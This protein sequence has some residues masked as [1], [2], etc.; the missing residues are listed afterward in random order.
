MA[1]PNLSHEPPEFNHQL[2]SSVCPYKH[3]CKEQPHKRK[4]KKKKRKKEKKK[5]NKKEHP[6]INLFD[7]TLYTSIHYIILLGVIISV[8]FFRISC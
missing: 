7:Y 1:N 6:H 2:L 8:S 3:Y 4:M 5:N